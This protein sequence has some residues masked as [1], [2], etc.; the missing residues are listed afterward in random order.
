MSRDL[1]EVR[2]GEQKPLWHAVGHFRILCHFR[3]LRHFRK[4]WAKRANFGPSV[5]RVPLGDTRADFT[6]STTLTQIFENTTNLVYRLKM[7]EIWL[8]VSR[9]RPLLPLLL[10]LLLQMTVSEFGTVVPAEFSG[11]LML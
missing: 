2:R 4:F 5:V 11:E 10:L 1:W 9:V 3:I 7:G 8:P 6:A